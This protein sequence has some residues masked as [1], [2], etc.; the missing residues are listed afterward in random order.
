MARF[1]PRCPS[2][3]HSG[4]AG[5]RR[6]MP[7]PSG[8]RRAAGC[9]G[10]GPAREGRGAAAG[11]WRPD[12]PDTRFSR[13]SRSARRSA[14][15][16][17]GGC[18]IPAPSEY[19]KRA[20]QAARAR[21]YSQAGD[22]YRLAGDWKRASEMYLKGRHFD[23]AARLSE[24]M[25]DLPAASLCYLK[26]G[27]LTA[28]G[29]IELRL[30][31][32]DKAAYLFSRCG[33]HDRAAEVFE[34][35]EQYEQAAEQYEKAGYRERAALLYVKA[36]THV[37]AA[38]LFES[39]IESSGEDAPGSFRSE[40]ER[41]NRLRY[42]RY[43]GELLLKV[44]EPAR[45]AVH[46]ESALMLE[47]AAEAWRLAGKAERA[48]DI[49]LRLQKPDRAYAVLREAGKELSSLSPAVQAEI[50]SRQGKHR[51]AAGV[52]ERA[53]SRY[54][55]AEAWREAGEAIRAAELFEQEGELDLAACLFVQAGNFARAARIYE[56]SRDY[57]NAAELFRKAGR[58]E[59]AARVLVKSGDP[60][61]AA[62][63]H[64]ERRDFDACIGALQKVGPDHPEYRKA[65]FLLGRIFSEQGLH[66]LAADKFI[67]AIGGE[68]VGDETVLIYYSLALAHEANLRPREALRIYQKILSY[69]YGYKDVLAR[70]RAVESRPLANLGARGAGR[71]ADPE[72]GWSEPNR[73]RIEASLGVGR[74]GEV[75]RAVDASLERPVAVRRLSEGPNEAGKADRFL[76]EAALTARLSHPNILTTYDT[77]ADG[78][79][80]FIVSALADGV[81]LRKL[82]DRKV[83][84]EVN[85]IVEIGRQVLEAL[86]HA[87][88]RGVLHRNLRPEN[89]FVAED[90][91]VA[92]SDFGLAV[93]LSDLTT[94]ELSSGHLIRYT[95]PEALLKERVD[96]RS[97]L[98]AF[99]IVLYEMAVGRP[100]FVG[101]EVGHQQVRAEVPLPGR[102]ERVI[103]GFLKGVILRCLEK[104]KER[105]YPDARAVLEDLRIREV[106][107]GMLVSDRYEVL[108]EVG[109]GGMGTIF[110]ARDVELDETVALKFLSG[111]IGSG[112]VARFVQEIKSARSIVH[113]NVV[114][115]FTLEKWR[116]HR[117]I[118]MEYIDGVPL[119]RWMERTPAPSRQDRLRLAAQLAR[120]LE[121]A[122]KNRIIH[123][124]IKPENILVD[125]KG[126][127]KV[128]DFGIARPMASGHTLTSTG[129]VIGS[130]MYMS[131]EQIQARPVD[132][133]ADLYSLGAV[134]YF[135]F[136]G[137]EPFAGGDVQEILMKHLKG[138]P[139]P[140]H[141]IDPSIP[142]P[143]S[144]SI[145]RC[146]DPDPGKRFPSARDLA[147][148][149]SSA[150]RPSAA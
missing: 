78:E 110:R 60:V 108:A 91:R 10:R 90:D 1:L 43:C 20:R 46:F 32:R 13:R 14:C 6:S 150:A 106:V 57:G 51:E 4:A 54:R 72:S 148:A 137:I 101:K 96:E 8:A 107:P 5:R 79:G 98:Y 74:L 123:R 119:Q 129:T 22:F 97:D 124:D 114:R 76:K 25:G 146:L 29:E 88:G 40:A 34:S 64:Y 143:V 133:R 135:L 145:M 49:L 104:D 28:A 7:D 48:A 83:R 113:P 38:G 11:R 111:N 35:L 105:R 42:H 130:P 69:D 94:E 138:P 132:A 71:A 118:V 116:E 102:G 17:Q 86:A 30:E 44:E 141:E 58:P 84:F 144:D 128:L 95:P 55:A 142:R 59:E 47:Q 12:P 39:I 127:A 19:I 31:N 125:V 82:L 149:L 139:R 15:Q 27:D 80:K 45:A 37:K 85:R 16:E 50:L 26:A 112:E 33:R 3:D 66:T 24:E 62:R 126:A 56:A 61:A 131:P 100:P 81:P 120:A 87:H 77:G 99:G 103:P 134:L 109:R 23:Q 9:P 115:V 70:M 75:F 93:R 63:I 73:Y 67:A 53:G 2:G 147:A 52:L 41:A 122:H 18:A 68:D 36:G 21:D 117:F 121:A 65:C 89:I 136:T 140:P 92:V